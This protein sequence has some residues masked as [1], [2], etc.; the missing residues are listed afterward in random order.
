MRRGVHLV[1]C[2]AVAAGT[3]TAGD[4]FPGVRKLMSDEEF[5]AANPQVR[6]ERNWMG[7][8][9]MTVLSTGKSVGVSPRR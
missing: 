6:I 5:R 1:L 8:Y 9:R 3:A 2:L 7:F 4:R